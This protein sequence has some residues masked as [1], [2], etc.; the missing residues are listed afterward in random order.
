MLSAIIEPKHSDNGQM[1]SNQ[2]LHARLQ[3]PLFRSKSAQFITE[4]VP[5]LR[6]EVFP[7]DEYVTIEVGHLRSGRLQLTELML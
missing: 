6:S 5:K 2:P 1:R 3:I 7:P 4:L